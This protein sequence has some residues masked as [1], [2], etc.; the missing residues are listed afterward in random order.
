[1]ATD[2][3]FV[4]ITA[5]S[6]HTCGLLANGSYACWGTGVGQVRVVRVPWKRCTAVLVQ[7]RQF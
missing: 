1:M 4:D 3:L 6:Y 2:L 5:G 7:M